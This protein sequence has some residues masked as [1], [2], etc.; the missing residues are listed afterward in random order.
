MREIECSMANFPLCSGYSPE[1]WQHGVEV[2]LLK[3]FN[4]FHVSKLRAILLFE[5]NFN[6]NN[7]QIG[8]SLMWQAEDECWLAPEQYGSRQNYSASDH[9]LNK[10]LW[11]DLLRQYKP[12]GAICVNDIKGCYDRIV[13][14]A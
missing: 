6:L 12:S 1:Q 11:F 5:A 14:S 4:N 8:R 9:C 13:H 3:Q 10:R 7:K 2:M